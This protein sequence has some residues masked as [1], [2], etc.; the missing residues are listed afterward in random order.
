MDDEEGEDEKKDDIPT[1]NEFFE[2]YEHLFVIAGVFGALALYMANIKTSI[3]VSNKGLLNLGVFSSLIL[4]VLLSL[5]IFYNAGE[6]F[7]VIQPTPS[8]EHILN[9]LWLVF[10]TMF[11]LTFTIVL[12]A[13]GSTL[14][15]LSAAFYY[16]T[17][18]IFLLLLLSIISQ[19][20]IKIEQSFFDETGS[21]RW[22]LFVVG[23]AGVVFVIFFF[24]VG[25]FSLQF[26]VNPSVITQFNPYPNMEKNIISSL[27]L[28]SAGVGLLSGGIVLITGIWTAIYAFKYIL[29]NAPTWFYD[30]FINNFREQARDD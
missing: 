22:L 14:F 8:D 25:H 11:F 24:F 21:F 13:I 9:I 19:S 26:N 23:F 20:Y 16:F 12:T 5:L 29:T 30:Y 3:P 18:F 10:G 7:G 28:A 4:F 6:E 1:L 17:T 15:S 27:L 2:T